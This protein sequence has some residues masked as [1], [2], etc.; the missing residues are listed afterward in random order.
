MILV[1]VF[2]KQCI[3]CRGHISNVTNGNNHLIV[4]NNFDKIFLERLQPP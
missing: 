4:F 3:A 2:N 1:I